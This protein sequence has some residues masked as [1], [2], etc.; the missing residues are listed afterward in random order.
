MQLNKCIDI[1]TF[2][3]ILKKRQ[4]REAAK[5]RSPSEKLRASKKAVKTKGPKLL[6]EAAKKA[7]KTRAKNSNM[8]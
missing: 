8:H 6:S 5:N 7:A 4:A 2:V 1:N 3:Y